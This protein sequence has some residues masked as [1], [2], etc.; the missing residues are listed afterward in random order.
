[1]KKLI[2]WMLV[3]AVA[4]V[5]Y[6]QTDT[7]QTGQSKEKTVSSDESK[8]QST[9]QA[10]PSTAA[11]KKKEPEPPSPYVNGRVQM[12]ES[13]FNFGYTPMNAT[14]FHSFFIKNVGT[15]TLDIVKVRPG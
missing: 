15:D 11:R 5:G 12:D 2:V 13:G 9:T 10:R 14:V 6:G 7:K 4:A 3:L 8:K 1:M